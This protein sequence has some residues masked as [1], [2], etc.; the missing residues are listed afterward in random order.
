MLTTSVGRDVATLA[1]AIGEF[2]VGA[3]SV[4]VGGGAE[5]AACEMVNAVPPTV[6]VAVRAAPVLAA[7]V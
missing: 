3:E 4:P 6:S 2:A 5:P 1:P 7:T